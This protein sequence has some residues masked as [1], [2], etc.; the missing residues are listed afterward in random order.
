MH[1]RI[2]MKLTMGAATTALALPSWARAQAQEHKAPTLYPD[3]AIE[4]IDP[5]FAEYVVF[6]AAVERLYTGARWAE[7]PGVVW[8]RTFLA[9]QRHPQQSNAALA[10]RYRRGECVP[11][12]VKLQQ[13]QLS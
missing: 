10:G 13:R 5:R 3:S 8:R 12:P 11:Q 9:I 2:F 7:G 4:I 1:R 6:N